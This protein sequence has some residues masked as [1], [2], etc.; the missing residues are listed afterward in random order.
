MIPSNEE[1]V[2]HYLVTSGELQKYLLFSKIAVDGC[3]AKGPPSV[4]K[5]ECLYRQTYSPFV[6]S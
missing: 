3:T 5:S 4:L 1:L 6:M 2:C